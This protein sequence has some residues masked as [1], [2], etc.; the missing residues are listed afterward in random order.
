MIAL[1]ACNGGDPTDP[2]DALVITDDDR[3]MGELMVDLL[4]EDPI[5][6][7]GRIDENG[8]LVDA[9]PLPGAV[10]TSTATNIRLAKNAIAAEPTKRFFYWAEDDK[11]SFD[12]AHLV[13]MG[14][15]VLSDDGSEIS[16]ARSDDP[17]DLTPDH[18]AR[19]VSANYFDH[20]IDSYL[21]RDAR[22]EHRV[23]VALRGAQIVDEEDG[24]NG[25]VRLRDIRPDHRRPRCVFI[26]WDRS[27]ELETPTLRAFTGSTV[28]S[29]LYL[30][31][32]QA[33]GDGFESC[34][35]PQGLHLR[36]VGNMGKHTNTLRQIS[37]TPVIREPS[38]NN[39]FYHVSNSKWDPDWSEG[40]PQK[41][42]T[43]VGAHIHCAYWDNK[44]LPDDYW[45]FS[46]R[47]C[48]TINGSVTNTAKRGEIKDFYDAMN[49]PDA[50][51]LEDGTYGGEKYGTIYPM[52][53][54]TGTEARLHAKGAVLS[55]MRRVR[56]GSSVDKEVS[57]DHP[58]L[59]LQAA[60]NDP[61]PDG[62][63]GGRSML[64]LIEAQRSGSWSPGTK[65]D[66]I[67]TP[68]LAGK[69]E[70]ELI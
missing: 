31:A 12:Y 44:S 54:L 39:D 17:F 62:D 5:N 10:M 33:I 61:D 63:F 27:P 55:E 43:L 16:T 52:V 26:V 13:G 24:E 70:I 19:M 69:Q 6:A 46:S 42:P 60:L 25:F 2:A 67:I 21:S 14:D 38:Q 47:G 36:Q 23:V 41:A 37:A 56:I 20:K 9:A 1:A 35:M 64:R 65:P 4:R 58:I 29:E 68:F 66:G 34:M 57:P 51:L 3:A 7:G 8:V 50:V 59:Q 30:A 49:L 32:Y 15:T 48:Q 45:F 28:P 11:N 18:I 40:R 53:L 22:T